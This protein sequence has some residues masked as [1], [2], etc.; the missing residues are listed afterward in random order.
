MLF[1]VGLCQ[2]ADIG[3]K[4]FRLIGFLVVA[5]TAGV[6]A[7]II[8]LGAPG[9]LVAVTGAVCICAAGLA[10]WAAGNK[11]NL[12]LFRAVT[13]FGGT[14]GLVAAI[15]WSHAQALAPQFNEP[16]RFAAYILGLTLG[17]W[18]MGTITVAWLLG[19]AYLTAT[20]MT[21]LPLQRLSRIL[22][23]AVIARTIF[24]ITGLV[25]F[26]WTSRNAGTGIQPL[27]NESLIL[28]LRIATGIVGLGVFT[29]MVRDCV[30]LRST[31]SATGILYFASLFAY[32]GELSSH[33][34][35]KG[36]G[37]PV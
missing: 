16:F 23:A 25:A 29:Y 24:L 19:H 36:L 18:I 17:A 6:A 27:M 5:V 8:R 26:W 21:I 14:L 34:L 37:W 3:W 28:S 9:S 12:T 4:F 33:Y 11:K 2:P 20:K 31:Q 7:W 1:V 30:R 15:L 13:L 32:I 35:V 10:Q 22:S